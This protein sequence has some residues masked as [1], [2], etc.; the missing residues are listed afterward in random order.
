MGVHQGQGG[1]LEVGA[2]VCALVQRNFHCLFSFSFCLRL[3]FGAEWVVVV[4]G[5]DDESFAPE[6]TEH[7]FECDS[8]TRLSDCG[9]VQKRDGNQ[10]V[11]WSPRFSMYYYLPVPLH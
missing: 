7:S 3:D 11:Q 4:L 10:E 1:G 5:V 9:Q 2:V 8:R 6:A